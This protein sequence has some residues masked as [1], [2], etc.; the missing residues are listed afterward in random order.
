[1]TVNELHSTQA[2]IVVI[3]IVVQCFNRTIRTYSSA[4][5][6]PKSIMEPNGSLLLWWK[7]NNSVRLM[8]FHFSFQKP[9]NLVSSIIETAVT[10]FFLWNSVISSEAD[11]SMWK[12]DISDS[13]TYTTQ[14]ILQLQYEYFTSWKLP[15]R[16]KADLPTYWQDITAVPFPNACM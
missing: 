3:V 10:Y 5:L 15:D 1:M 8:R 4:L 7:L 13:L 12:N 9:I 14:W 11:G 2:F 6:K 16:L